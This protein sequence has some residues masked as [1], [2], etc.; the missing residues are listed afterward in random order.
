MK[1]MQ[2]KYEKQIEHFRDN[3]ENQRKQ[4][5]DDKFSL[6]EKSKHPNAAGLEFDDDFDLDGPIKEEHIRVRKS[7]QRLDDFDDEELSSIQSNNRRQMMPADIEMEFDEPE[8]NNK[9]NQAFE[10]HTGENA[11][12]FGS[13]GADVEEF[14]SSD[15]I[16]SEMIA[17]Y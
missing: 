2:E 3:I 4:M 12:Y 15:T 1:T 8:S 5:V 11:S 13:S 9:L 7:R 6:K 17:A 14:E 10:H 16:D